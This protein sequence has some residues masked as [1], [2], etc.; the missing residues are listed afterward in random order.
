MASRRNI[1]AV[2][3]IGVGLSVQ[4]PLW[5]QRGRSGAARTPSRVPGA[6]KE[7]RTPIDEFETMSPE[8]QQKALNRL[9]PSERQKLQ[10]RLKRF[11]SLPPEQQQAL[12]SLYNRL[13]QLPPERQD[14]VRKAIN[15]ISEQPA[16]R[17]QAIRQE[18]HDLAALAPAE[19]RAR[20]ATPGFRSQFSKKEQEILRDMSPLLP[21]R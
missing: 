16:Q 3:A 19:R 7:Q 18:L 13:H 12:K 21:D 6:E 10:E 15:K 5:A 9:S 8:E 1:L 20:M 4:S 11:N 2:A 14:A 17:Q